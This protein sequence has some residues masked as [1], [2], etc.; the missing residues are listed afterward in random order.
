MIGLVTV[1]LGRHKTRG[2]LHIILDIGVRG[3]GWHEGCGVR[4]G[5]VQLHRAGLAGY[6]RV[7]FGR[8][9]GQHRDEAG[10]VLIGRSGI[11][12]RRH[13]DG[14]GEGSDF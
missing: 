4:L 9:R 5:T 12:R 11:S 14:V 2:G 10:P 7:R 6:G 8:V 3:R 13:V 1:Q